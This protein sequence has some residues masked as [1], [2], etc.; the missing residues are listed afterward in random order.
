MLY[1]FGQWIPN[2]QRCLVWRNICYSKEIGKQS[3][4]HNLE[5]NESVVLYMIYRHDCEARRDHGVI[6]IPNVLQDLAYN[7]HE[8]LLWNEKSLCHSCT[9]IVSDFSESDSYMLTQIRTRNKAYFP[10]ESGSLLSVAAPF[11]GTLLW[12][13]WEEVACWVDVRD[14]ICRL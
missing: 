9:L 13:H 2:C 4:S 14:A 8:M 7:M 3:F 6:G 12:F 10:G 11:D 5:S 1:M